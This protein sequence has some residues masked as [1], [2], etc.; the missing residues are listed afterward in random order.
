MDADDVPKKLDPDLRAFVKAMARYA[1]HKDHNE[2]L[3]GKRDRR[4]AAGGA[5]GSEGAMNVTVGYTR[6][7][8]AI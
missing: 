2:A 8:T 3:K 4:A 5:E 6:K 1:A 7:L